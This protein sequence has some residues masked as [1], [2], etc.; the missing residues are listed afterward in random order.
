ME[1]TGKICLFHK[2]RAAGPILSYKQENVCVCVC[3][4]MILGV[5]K[6]LIHVRQPPPLLLCT[7]F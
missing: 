3:K 4:H 2:F 1:E 6:T 5:C 7:L